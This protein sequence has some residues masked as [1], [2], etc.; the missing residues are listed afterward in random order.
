MLK[1]IAGRTGPALSAAGAAG[2]AAAAI[3]A[4]GAVLG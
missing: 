1:I 2:A 3:L 4:A